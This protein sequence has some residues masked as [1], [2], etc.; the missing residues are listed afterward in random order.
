MLGPCLGIESK[1]WNLHLLYQVKLD[2]CPV[3]TPSLLLREAGNACHFVKQ[4]M[5]HA[6]SLD[7]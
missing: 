1:T 2:I 3:F 7:L 4:N 6:A 5:L